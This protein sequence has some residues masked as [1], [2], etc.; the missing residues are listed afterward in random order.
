MNKKSIIVLTFLCVLIT[1]MDIT[2]LPGA[3]LKITLA[4]VN[5]Y[6]LPLMINFLFIGI[7]SWVVI[8]LFRVDMKF[9]FTR[10]GLKDG[11]K[12]YALPSIIAGSL[13]FIAFFVGL[14]PYDYK[15]TILK[16]LIEGILYYI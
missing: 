7:I 15:P 1:F 2:G 10:N 12:R 4:D 13:S 14:F 5:V 16:I 9:G 6:I 11:L 8:K 3:L